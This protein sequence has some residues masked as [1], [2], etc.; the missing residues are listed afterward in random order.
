MSS[1]MDTVQL[2]GRHAAVPTSEKSRLLLERE[3]WV[4]D[5]SQRTK[6]RIRALVFEKSQGSNFVPEIDHLY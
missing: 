1:S 2:V 3:N 5:I 6:H 4:T